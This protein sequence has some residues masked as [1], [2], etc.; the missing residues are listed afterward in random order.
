MLQARGVAM[1]LRSDN[2]LSKIKL[3]LRTR[4]A[5]GQAEQTV[6]VA[7]RL[8]AASVIVGDKAYPIH[9][10]GRAARVRVGAGRLNL[11]AL[12]R[13]LGATRPD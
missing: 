4:E 11:A 3:A 8:T 1:D 13:L 2:T 6:N 9:G 5:G 12:C 10:E 7:V